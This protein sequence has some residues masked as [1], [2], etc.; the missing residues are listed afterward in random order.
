MQDVSSPLGQAIAEAAAASAADAVATSHA[1][2][3]ELLQTPPPSLAAALERRL[4]RLAYDLHD[5]ALQELAALAAEVFSMRR[6]VVPLVVDDVRERIDGRF[7]DVQAR[8]ASVDETLRALVASVK[9]E[10]EATEALDTRIARD[11]AAIRDETG[12]EADLEIMGSFADLTE[13]RRIAI[14]QVVHEALSNV[15]EHSGAERV[16]VRV[17]ER[18]GR[19]EVSVEDD[20]GGFDLDAAL[21][22]ASLLRRFG[23][24]GMC[25]RVAMLGSELYID[26][27]PGAGTRISF[28]LDR[29][30]PLHRIT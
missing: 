18:E 14:F 26:S 10:P 24:H 23:L 3:N 19:V 11:V 21:L 1:L 20:G 30:V 15:R 5:G 25:E 2:D 6:Q 29:W 7:D 9:G 16:S 13:S 22:E 17:V 28:T 8:L 12:I 4:R 27:E